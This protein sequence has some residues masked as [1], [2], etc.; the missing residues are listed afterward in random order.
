MTE[1]FR[2]PLSETIWIRAEMAECLAEADDLPAAMAEW[3]RAVHEAS[4]TFGRLESTTLWLRRRYTW[5]IGEAGDP[6]RA[7]TLLTAL[8]AEAK[9]L[10]DEYLFLVFEIRKS[11]AWWTGVTGDSATALREL[12]ALLPAAYK[13]GDQDLDLR[14]VKY[15]LAY[16]SSINGSIG[17]MSKRLQSVIEQMNH[18]LGPSHPVT[19]A[20]R[21]ELDARRH[22]PTEPLN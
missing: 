5:S 21:H 6:S 11:L 1:R 3:E 8:L 14:S 22:T 2:S 10:D 20:A 13:R 12:S 17:D 15:M 4:I 9:E 7:A 19:R 16:W 18:D